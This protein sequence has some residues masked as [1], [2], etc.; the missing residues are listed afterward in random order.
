MD[1]PITALLPEIQ[2]S[3]A[4]HPRLVLE[5]PPGAGKTTQ[6]PLALRDAPWLAGRKI[7]MLEPRR[8]AARSAAMFMARQLGEEVGGTV[9]YRIR[10]EHRV[11]AATR[12]EVVTEGILTRMIQDDPELAGVGALLF[13][14]FHERHLA[15][16][17]GLALALDVQS[18]LRKD[19]RLVV[20]SATLDGERLAAFL[21]APRLS[22]AGRSHP[23]AIEH[24]PARR[25]EALEA[26]LRRA[27]EQA[28]A[29]HPGD[30]LAFLPGRREIARAE[31]ALQ[32]AL[33]EGA[34]REGVDILQLHGDLPVEQQARVLQPGPDGR[35]RV[36]LATN[37]AESSVTLPGV[38]VVVDSGLAREPR[39]DPNSGFS[40][41]D[42][43]T[44]S[45]ASADQRAGRAGRVAEGWSY[46]L[47]PAS[48]RLEPQR[49]PEIAQV[50]LAGLALEL[51]AWGDA[52]LR[53][54]DPPPP[55]ALAAARELLQRLDAL[56]ADGTITSMGRRMLALGTHPRLAAML[57]AAP[58]GEVRALAC[59]LAALVE[60]RDPLRTRSD[61]WR[62]RWLALAAF[63]DGR[64][65]G[66]AHRGALATIDA[67][68]RQWRRRVG[69]GGPP[70]AS[71]PAHLAGDVLAHAFPDRIGRVHPR[72]PQ[73]YVLANGRMARLADDSGLRGEPW[74][75]ASELRFE[76]RDS[77]VLRGAP[78]DEAHLRRAW[79]ARFLE[80]DEVRW[81]AER[82][83]LVAERVARFDGIV[84]DVRP[85]GRVDPALA[86]QALTDAVAALGLDA[87]PWSD[88]LRQW[89]ARVQSLRAWAPDLG[90]PD[91]SDAAL[92]ATRE[93]WLRPLFE[94]ASRIDALPAQALS[95]ALRARLAWEQRRQLDALAPARIRV[96][97]GMERGIAYALGHDGE[98]EP[99][100]LAIKL[101]ELFGLGETPAIVDGRVPLTLH[102]LSPAGRPLQVT[103][104]LRSFWERTW[105][106][107]R[108]EMKGRYPR[109]PWPEDPWNAAATHRA[110]PR[111]T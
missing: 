20:M 69:A 40:R 18:A 6:V 37:V 52:G 23:V 93:D 61:G 104:D 67:A 49:R 73:R 76:H 110:K 96:P 56:G 28:L 77:L 86:A 38:R 109:H 34:G 66:E 17:L 94:G 60:A 101:Q 111:G 70:P 68:A 5:A 91:L 42:A 33:T 16:D 32:Q 50:E 83:A 43:V 3:L 88:E 31:A 36:V 26:Q 89:R 9:G 100:V 1:F 53:F 97:S 84:L 22:S 45:Q 75:V 87:L 57:L 79:P 55:G 19:L 65:S 2:R 63:R 103:R 85:A 78:V 62:E 25:D 46:R 64:V 10:F 7:V 80:R 39:Y 21:D 92:M 30:V 107:V 54:L 35:R 90:L 82:R 106:E 47:W 98:P 13:D 24:F 8:V 48:Q 51:A 95:D 105:P 59:D 102:L 4:A 99:P 72:D 81:D 15:G 74:I 58:E 12:I 44:V 71:L 108:R 14:E 27:V 29:R 11:S 41:L